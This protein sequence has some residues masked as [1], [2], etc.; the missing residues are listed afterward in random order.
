PPPSAPAPSSK[1]PA[2][3]TPAAPPPA[4][5][6]TTGP[7]ASDIADDVIDEILEER[8]VYDQQ[9]KQFPGSKTVANS[10]LADAYMFD[11]LA[12]GLGLKSWPTPPNRQALINLMA[13]F[14]AD[15]K[16]ILSPPAPPSP[17]LQ[18][19]PPVPPKEN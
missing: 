5:A 12:F 18:N 11:E 2:S 16:L 14:L 19:P 6:P 15:V 3:S 9:L 1:P 13:A 4:S 8:F 17:P 10:L 7:S